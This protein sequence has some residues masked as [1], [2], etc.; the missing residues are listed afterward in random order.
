MQLLEI[1]SGC[2]RS[3][4][5]NTDVLETAV[6]RGGASGSAGDGFGMSR[7]GSTFALE[8]PCI[9]RK[10]RGIECVKHSRPFKG[11][12]F[13]LSTIGAH[14]LWST[15][16]FTSRLPELGQ[17]SIPDRLT[18]SAILCQCQRQTSLNS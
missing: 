12:I 3:L 9:I 4:D 14:G 6:R 17:E 1:L 8:F 18:F 16:I 7:S 5:L 10:L 11:M 2:N 13:K 15:L